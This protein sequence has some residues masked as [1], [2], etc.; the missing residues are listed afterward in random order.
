MGPAPEQ[1]QRQLLVRSLRHH[2]EAQPLRLFQHFLHR[3]GRMFSQS[4]FKNEN[5]GAEFLG[6]SN[7]LGQG[8]GLTDNANVILDRKNLAQPGAEDRLRVGHNHTYEL[9]P[10]LHLRRSHSRISRAKG[11]ACHWFTFVAHQRRSNRYSSITRPTPRLPPCSSLR[12]TRPWHSTFTSASA[13]TTS[14]GREMVKSTLEPIGMST[15]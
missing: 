10:V 13:P 4:R 11:R 15:S 3:I 7:G 2:H 12:T 8:L 1:L 5:F 9:L 6:R 14:A